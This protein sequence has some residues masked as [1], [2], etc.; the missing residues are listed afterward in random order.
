M[1]YAPNIMQ[2]NSNKSTINY[3]IIEKLSTRYETDQTSYTYHISSF[4]NFNTTNASSRIFND[5]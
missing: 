2:M 3:T 5:R 1:T 4:D